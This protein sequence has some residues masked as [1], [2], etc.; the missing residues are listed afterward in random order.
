M[1]MN[2]KLFFL[3]AIFALAVLAHNAR[4]QALYSYLDEDGVRVFTNIAPPDRSIRE[5]QMVE[6]HSSAAPGNAPNPPQYPE[7]LKSSESFDAIIEKYAQY[8]SLDPSLIRSIIATESGFNPKAISAK[9]A[10]GLMQLM[11]A[12]AKRLGVQNSFDPEQNIHGGIKHFRSLLDIFNNDLVLSL[13]A[14]NA[15]ENLV[16]RLGRVPAIKET[17][18][19]VRSVTKRYEKS[20]QEAQ[21]REGKR[22]SPTFRFYDESGVLNLTNIPPVR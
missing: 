14:Y 2:T 7:L 22:Q 12:T 8:Y 13:A 1:H 15:G 11:P 18:D 3:P 17:H 6:R 10:R 4:G 5:V 19:Y 20:K 21:A 16:Q 9:G